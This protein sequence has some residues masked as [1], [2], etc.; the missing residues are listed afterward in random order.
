MFCPDGDLVSLH[1]LLV[2]ALWTMVIPMVA[3]LYGLLVWATYA[4]YREIPW[5]HRQSLRALLLRW[6]LVIFSWI[7]SA[8]VISFCGTCGEES[9][10]RSHWGCLS[11]ATVGASLGFG[12]C[13]MLLI[14]K[15][16]RDEVVGVKSVPFYGSK[17]LS[18]KLVVVTGA[19][20]GIGFETT[21]QLAAQGATVLL[22]C[23]NP[24]R[25]G[26]AIREICK[27]QAE[28]HASDPIAHPTPEISESK[29]VFVRVDLTVFESI[30]G[31]VETICREVED[32]SF[33]CVDA[34][35]LN[36]GTL[37]ERVIDCIAG[38]T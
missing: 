25:A 7:A 20:N 33:K 38:M 14:R 13:G 5:G 32:R 2:V 24:S 1:R 35:V 26:T 22:L 23:R 30:R 17:H 29:L 3:F 27:L 11:G 19:N 18:N 37:F 8:G 4:F 10:S 31:A 15:T 6:I 28:L 21:R 36:A 34:L 12:L 9:P 16:R